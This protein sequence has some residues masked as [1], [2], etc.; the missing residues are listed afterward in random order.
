MTYV[1]S[2]P[3][4]LQSLGALNSGRVSAFLPPGRLSYPRKFRTAPRIYAAACGR[5]GV[6]SVAMATLSDI[7]VL[8]PRSLLPPPFR[9]CTGW[10]G[11]I[12]SKPKTLGSLLLPPPTNP[13]NCLLGGGAVVKDGPG[14]GGGRV[15]RGQD[16]FIL[17]AGFAKGYSC[18]LARERLRTPW[19]WTF[20]FFQL[21]AL[22]FIDVLFLLL[23]LV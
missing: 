16:V 11:V 18:V 17:T 4:W 13:V 19:G 8:F 3:V 22:F 6:Q 12:L 20:F 10:L 14:E 1:V 9:C 15:P 5:G 23:V 21:K 7:V 2:P